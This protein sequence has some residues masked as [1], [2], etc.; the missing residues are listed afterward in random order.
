[1]DP[2][3]AYVERGVLTGE[4]AEHYAF[5]AAC[6]LLERAT[7]EF[8]SPRAIVVAWDPR[9]VDGRFAGAV[10]RGVLRARALL[11]VAGMF[12]TPAA[13]VYMAGV[14]AAGAIVLTASHNPSDQNGIKI[15]LGP[16]ALK[17]LPEEDEELSALLWDSSWQEV[18]E[19]PE[20]GT[21]TDSSSEARAFYADYIRR[22]ANGWLRPGDLAEWDVVLDPARGAWSGLAP[23]TMEELGAR[24]FAEVNCLGDGPVNEGGGVVA[25]EG[26]R[27]VRGGE[28][29][30]IEAHA[31]L[32]RLFEVGRSRAE[33]LRAGEGFSVCGV[34]DAD[35]DR[36]CALV[37]DP[38]EDSAL[39][40]GGD[41]SLVLQARF[42]KAEE[43]LPEN[44]VAVVT[45][46]SDAG[47]AAALAELGLRV[48]FAPVGD[49]W[50]LHFADRFEGE[51]V[52]GGEES[53]HTIVPGRLSDASGRSR[54]LPVG[55]GLKGFLNTCAA[56]RRLTREMAPEAAYAMLA[57]PFPRGFKKALY[58]YHVDRARFSPGSE[59]WEAV[60]RTL[61][62]AAGAALPDSVSLRW[63][64]LEDDPAVMYLA[65]DLD[66]RP[67]GAIYIRNSGTERRTGVVLR[68]PKEW[69]KA[70]LEA[71]GAAIR[72]LLASLKDAQDPG[73][74]AERALLQ[75]LA[76]GEADP[77]KLEEL[78]RRDAEANFGAEVAPERICKEALRGGLAER[79]GGR[80]AL[81]GLGRWF[82]ENWSEK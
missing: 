71:G 38:F 82:L 50:L 76:E 62:E 28:G 22:L 14:G 20:G 68:G 16:R 31:G 75:G 43:E 40:L 2:R 25:L 29:D 36:A 46:E 67:E 8:I 51:F 61:H 34:F 19:M 9:D 17:P 55:D 10:M 72:P 58:V 77:A 12:P 18:V 65:L 24:S 6:W 60:S 69:G 15:F 79:A 30:V 47:A 7:E 39:V 66:G 1:M 80:M 33:A 54:L 11:L 13:A 64:P 23:E 41:E 70:L 32:R 59:T 45:I 57:A 26:R 56:I 42:L 74:R 73:A 21:C 63:A 35:G 49:K 52:C 81:T 3:Q 78:L 44:G 4:F 37:Y 53:G 27:A 5:S 48:G